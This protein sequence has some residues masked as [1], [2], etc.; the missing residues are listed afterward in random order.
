M[1]IGVCIPELVHGGAGMS[2]RDSVMGNGDNRF[3]GEI[4]SSDTG[5]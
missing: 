1:G 3:R 2:G 4:K 5:F